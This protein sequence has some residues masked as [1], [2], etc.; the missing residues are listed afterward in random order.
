MLVDEEDLV[1]DLEG[2]LVLLLELELP[3]AEQVLPNHPPPSLRVDPLGGTPVLVGLHFSLSLKCEPVLLTFLV[4]LGKQVVRLLDE[5][6]V[7]L[8]AEQRP[9]LP[10]PDLACEHRPLG[11][12]EILLLKKCRG[13]Q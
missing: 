13:L 3:D 2:L 8:L 11:A 10:E 7:F 4:D 12:A 9:G 1:D 6:V 5:D